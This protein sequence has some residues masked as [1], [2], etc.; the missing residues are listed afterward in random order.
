MKLHSLRPFRA[1]ATILVGSVLLTGAACPADEL[2]A[3]SPTSAAGSYSLS[4]ID[5]SG[6]SCAP[7]TSATGGCT[8]QG[9]GESVVVVKSGSMALLPNGTFTFSATGTRDGAAE[10][11]EDIAGTWTEANGTVSFVVPGVPIPIPATSSGGG[12]QLL[13]VLPG[14]VFSS[15]QPMVTVAFAKQ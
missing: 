4:L 13:F 7:A 2:V 1:V 3:P 12:A 6:A 9:T 14:Q 5:Q 8:I 11:F 15:T 10:R